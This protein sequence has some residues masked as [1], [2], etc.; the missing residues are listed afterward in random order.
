MTELHNDNKEKEQSLDE[1]HKIVTKL[2]VEY[3]KLIKEF[4]A[5]QQY[6]IEIE[7]ENNQNKKAYDDITKSNLMIDKLNK[8]NS[9]LKSEN[10]LL[11]KEIHSMKK[12][13]VGSSTEKIK[14]EK[15]IKEKN[16]QISEM[17]NQVENYESLILKRD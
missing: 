7:T 5:L 1:S 13:T 11:K 14:F 9:S 17:K 10:D 6:S 8:Q 15:E 16:S 2:N 3:S 4:R 12:D